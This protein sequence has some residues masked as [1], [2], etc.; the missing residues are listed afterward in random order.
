MIRKLSGTT[1]VI[2]G[3]TSGIGREAAREFAKTGAKVVLAGRRKERL[4][5]LASE[6]EAS[7]G[8]ALSVQT[9][10]AEQ[11][12]V[13]ALI[14]K[15][16]ERFGRVDVLVNN[17]GVAMASQFEAMSLEDFR[18]LMDVNFWGAVYACRAAV[19]QMR[20]QRGGGV[21]L[22]VSSIFGKRGMPFETAY[23]AS[24]FALAGFSEA[25]RAE[26]MS[27]GIDV[28]TVYPGAV[29][30]E[31][32]DAAAN[33][34]GL[35]VPGFVPKFPASQMAKL[36]VQTARFPQP[37]VVAAFDAQAINIANTFAPALVD[38][39]LGWSVPFIE[40]MRRG[41]SQKDPSTAGSGN[42]YQPQDEHKK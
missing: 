20:K 37:E 11:A 7:G 33:S 8:Q 22:N 40:G 38:L 1:A 42:L 26:L 36:I 41:K 39:A 16:V 17:A 27:E 34:T 31:I 30:T 6:I 19:P 4:L 14:E 10:V 24:K 15:C 13:E 29:E 5:E 25:L 32:F 21:I 35:E 3:A 28:C 18:R 2:T 23:C 9:D 12:Q